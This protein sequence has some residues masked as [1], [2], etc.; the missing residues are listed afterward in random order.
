[1]GED[2][3]VR[4]SLL[5]CVSLGAVLVGCSAPTDP[6][7]P[8]GPEPPPWVSTDVTFFAM[9][10][11]QYGGGAD[12]KNTFQILA[13][14]GFPG[15]I[16]PD[17]TPFA[18]D[19]LADPRGVLIAGDLTQN[20][21][22][23][24]LTPL[25][26]DELGAFHADYGLTGVEG[27]LRFPVY[28]G[29][30]NHDFDPAQ[31]GDYDEFDW[32]FYYSE[33]GTPS[34]DSVAERNPDRIG[35]TSVAPDVDGHYSWDW[36]WL[37]L[38]NMDLFPGDEPSDAEANALTRDPRDALSFLQADLAERVGDTGRPVIVMAHYG[39]DGFGQEPR[40][41]TDEQKEA[42][43]A[44]ISGYDVSYIH[45]HTHATYEYEIDGLQCFNVGSPYYTNYN[46][47]GRGHFTVF[48][49]TDAAFVAY[50]VAW[51]FTADGA[52]AVWGDWSVVR[53]R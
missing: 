5:L 18:G 17:D 9:G 22:D 52:E 37:H 26:S 48:R 38:V 6:E 50:D 35:L 8:V 40:W 23:G 44:V 47:D 49:I 41:W 36:D 15:A 31:A 39:F 33:D 29:Y 21:Q 16:W 10:D 45:G 3:I 24:R 42:F 27:E 2:P 53:E 43:R 25:D 46:A 32:R 13:M 4:Y 19:V 30:G 1:M 34:A 20:G 11:P 14:N 28:E 12:D 51:E 7:P